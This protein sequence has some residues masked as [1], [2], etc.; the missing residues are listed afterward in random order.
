M[1]VNGSSNGLPA[2][3][4]WGQTVTLPVC[5][6]MMA[7]PLYAGQTWEIGEVLVKTDVAGKVC[8]KFVLTD[9]TAIAEGWV[10]TEAHVA[11]GAGAAARV[12]LRVG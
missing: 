2:E 4:V 10:I 7:Y 1:I 12:G 5:T 6:P 3:L 8:V 9:S 11:V